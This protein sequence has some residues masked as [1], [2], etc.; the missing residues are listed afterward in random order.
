[1]LAPPACLCAH[2][3]FTMPSCAHAHMTSLLCSALKIKCSLSFLYV[4]SV[5]DSMFVWEISVAFWVRKMRTI[6]M[7]LRMQYKPFVYLCPSISIVVAVLVHSLQ[8]QI[9]VN[10]ARV[11]IGVTCVYEWVSGEW[12]YVVRFTHTYVAC[13]SLLLLFSSILWTIP[14]YVYSLSLTLYISVFNIGILRI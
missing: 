8:Y 10:H 12:V 1:M 3:P 13:S 6:K 4:L 5:C 11:H 2:E 7:C 9:W 14:R